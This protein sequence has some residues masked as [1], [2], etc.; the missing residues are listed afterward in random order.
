MKIITLC[1]ST[2]FKE[3]FEIENRRLTL[4]GNIVI[5][6]GVFGHH[7]NI[8]FTKAEKELLDKIHFKKIKMSDEIKVIN[9]DNYIGNSTRRE[10]EYA[11]SL[12]KKVTYLYSEIKEA[13]K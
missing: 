10:I 8:S 13:T 6:V 5:S 7:D 11:K 9:A 2:K 4:E 1:G 3:Q 12:G